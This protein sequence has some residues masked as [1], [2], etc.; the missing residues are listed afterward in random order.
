MGRLAPAI[1]SWRAR[2]RLLARAGAGLAVL[3]TAVILA[4][5]APASGGEITNW[6]L[7]YYGQGEGRVWQQVPVAGASCGNGTPFHFFF[8]AGPA[9]VDGEPN[10]RVVVWF[11]GGGSTQMTRAGELSS[12]I[13]NLSQLRGRLTAEAGFTGRDFIFTDHAAN[14]RFIGLA[15]W[16]VLPYCTQDF[17]SGRRTE[18]HEYDFSGVNQLVNQISDRINNQGQTPEQVEQEFPGLRIEG[19]QIGNTFNV[20]GAFVS[21]T[22][23]GALN[24]EEALPLINQRLFQ[25]GVD[26]DSAEVLIAGSSAGGFGTWYHAWRVGDFLY[27]RPDVKLTVLPM[28]GSPSSR[29][30]DGEDIVETVEER[31]GLEH[32]LAWHDVQR[33][34]DVAGG[35]YT[36]ITDD[37]CDDFLDLLDH[38]RARWPDMDVQFLPVVNKEDLVA[39]GGLGNEGDPGFEERLLTFCQTVHR[40]SQ[41]AAITPDTLPYTEWLSERVW[42]GNT[43]FTKRVH[44]FREATLLVP[45]RDPNGSGQPNTTGLLQFINDVATRSVVPG[46]DPVHIEHQAGLVWNTHDPNSTVVP[47]MDS[48]QGLYLPECNVPAPKGFRPPPPL[49]PETD[50]DGDGCTDFQE[51]GYDERFGGLRDAE[52]YWDFFDTPDEANAR[53]RVITGP[54]IARVVVRFGSAGNPEVDPLSPPPPAPGYHSSFDRGPIQGPHRWSLGEADGAV[55]GTDISAIVAQFGHNCA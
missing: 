30:W 29:V 1:A 49:D 14:D 8:S 23:R 9:E 42:N 35:A 10:S 6:P 46:A 43:W 31:L 52:S 5:A 32:R 12:A 44:G 55:V 37:P 26:P 17:H 25:A 39:V 40:Y 18:P 34:C 3:A 53:D 28:S 4:P 13:N 36:A 21:I 54:D 7:G 27:G 11:P 33:P 24:V 15:H 38:Y 41:Y 47:W 20:T 16:V 2:A 22:H 19:T 48:D 51:A 45:M 50:T